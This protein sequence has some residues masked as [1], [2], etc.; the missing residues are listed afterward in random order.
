MSSE[1]KLLSAIFFTSSYLPPPPPSKWSENLCLCV[2]AL[3]SEQ[4]IIKA[5]DSGWMAQ[6]CCC[7]SAQ[8]VCEHEL[9]PE[10]PDVVKK[11]KSPL[12]SLSLRNPSHFYSAALSS[13]LLFFGLLLLTAK[14]LLSW[15]TANA[16][17]IPESSFLQKECK[18]W[19]RYE[20]LQE[21]LLLLLELEFVVHRG[22]NKMKTFV[23]FIFS[24][25][26][27]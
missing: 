2:T 17:S 9:R 19:W 7:C 14:V 1:I 12:T 10:T 23:L 20:R 4:Q 5:G 18:G 21:R 27:N 15:L 11:K 3:L 22:K 24:W 26:L 25:K 13:I 8:S 16:G 6:S